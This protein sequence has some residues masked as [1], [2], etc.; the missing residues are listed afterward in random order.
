MDL[1][2]LFVSIWF[3]LYL[4]SFWVNFIWT[5]TLLFCIL[6]YCSLRCVSVGTTTNKTDN[7]VLKKHAFFI[8]WVY[9]SGL[10]LL[11]NSTWRG[12]P[13]TLLSSEL[14]DTAQGTLIS[15]TFSLETA[16]RHHSTMAA[17]KTEANTHHTILYSF[18]LSTFRLLNRI[19]FIHHI[20]HE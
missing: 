10:I 19:I 16:K 1:F 18:T 8:S 17:Y 2:I 15:A 6:L 3:I 5:I 11:L 9:W 13:C 4:F 20:L 12:W 7:L 14:R